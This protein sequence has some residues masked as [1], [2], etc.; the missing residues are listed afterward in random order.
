M[1]RRSVS[2]LICS[3]ML[4]V[5]QCT[6]VYA[7]VSGNAVRQKVRVGIVKYPLYAEQ[8]SNGVWTGYDVEYTENIMQHAGLSVEF[9][10]VSGPDEVNEAIKSG[11]IDMCGDISSTPDR[12]GKYLFSEYEQGNSNISIIVRRGENDIEYGNITQ[13]SKLRYAVMEGTIETDFSAWCGEHGIEPEVTVCS[14]YKKV[15]RLLDDGDV[16]A[17]V[18]GDDYTPGYNTVYSFASTPYYYIFSIKNIAL[19][20]KVD[21]AMAEI[22][23]H[24]PLYEENLKQK[25]GINSDK[26]TAFSRDEKEYIKSH[27]Q[28]TVAMIKND[29]PYFKTAQEPVGFLPDMYDKISDNTGLHF[30]YSVYDSQ[31]EAIDAVTSGKAD[32]L[33][34]YSN[35]I[36]YAYNLGLRLTESYTNTNLVMLTYAGRETDS[37]KSIAVKKRSY[38]SVRKA[39]GAYYSEA[40]FVKF[41]TSDE[42]FKALKSGRTDATVIALPSATYL[43][44]QYDSSAYS[45]IPLS[46]TRLA[47]CGAVADD[48]AVLVSIL[49]KG[50]SMSAP[51]VDGMLAR[52]TASESSLRTLVAKIPTLALV[53]FII[54]SVLIVFVL[55]MAV[56]SLL[57]SRKDILEAAETRSEAEQQRIHAEESYRSAVEKNTF[58]SNI[59]HDMRTPLNAV[60]G[61]AREAKEADISAE[62]RNEYLD[63]I[64]ISGKMLLN[65]INDTLTISKLNSG[66]LVLNAEPVKLREI[67]ASIITPVQ[68]E[69]GAKH[70]TV[71]S[72]CVGDADR[73]LLMDR[74]KVQKI[75]LNLM[76]NAVK[77]TP[78]GGHVDLKIYSARND[79]GKPE[80]VFRVKDDGIGMSQSFIS[81]MY[82]PFSQEK[83]HG[84]ETVG[85]G[86]GLTIVKQLV[87]LMNGTIEVDSVKYRGTTV[88]IKLPLAETEAPAAAEENAEADLE[89]LAGK[90]LLVCEDNELNREIAAAA[91]KEKG[92]TADMAEDGASGLQKFLKSR[93]GEYAAILMD[94]RMPVMDGYDAARAIR[95]AER[96]DA[97]SVPIIAMTADAFPEYVKRCMDNGMNGHVAKP[98]EPEELYEI[99]SRLMITAENKK[100][101]RE[102]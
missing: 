24:E 66:K 75:C 59:S 77:Y 85:T 69:A 22:L 67:Y 8:D 18:P 89:G 71:T 30:K 14:D 49:N 57:K 19:K 82:E 11:K 56:I 33:G 70:I 44:N 64:E 53:V 13:L 47:V 35:G 98:F 20:N 60:L 76:T 41:D 21:A 39:V 36:P 86:L 42:C 55:V 83:R 52:N 51:F 96:A 74:L 12:R 5:C 79:D 72:E 92:M 1:T 6:A 91:L 3:I 34:I 78:D 90:K 16:D 15:F 101:A 28:V 95:G 17:A 50:I 65:L 23:N 99:L 73:T 63:K 81:S 61:F 9:V 97:A 4:L 31:E 32:V 10:P 102:D 27:P 7:G 26:Y 87:D 94:I 40:Q 88:T 100:T 37:I 54:M 46:G 80:T 93:E 25:Y 43:V 45:F 84:Y 29:R 48:N 68:E 38:D 2:L 58:F 62:Q